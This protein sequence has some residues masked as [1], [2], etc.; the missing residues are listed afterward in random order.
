MNI[1]F[2]NAVAGL[3]YVISIC[4][5]MY[6]G[7]VAA[8]VIASSALFPWWSVPMMVF[9]GIYLCGCVQRDMFQRFGKGL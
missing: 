1:I 9:P 3:I 2:L 7:T 5:I 6:G 8:A 4:S